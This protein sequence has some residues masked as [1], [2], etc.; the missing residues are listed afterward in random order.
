MRK[1]AVATPWSTSTSHL[2]TFPTG[3]YCDLSCHGLHR[4]FN[5]AASG[6][7]FAAGAG[8]VNAPA[9]TYF[10]SDQ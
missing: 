7:S 2:P 4:H 10:P 3:M 5:S 9:L 6:P 8:C 1:S